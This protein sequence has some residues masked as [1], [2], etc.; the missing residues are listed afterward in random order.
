MTQ[1]GFYRIFWLSGHSRYSWS[2]WLIESFN[3]KEVTYG[4]FLQ[5]FYKGL[6][7]FLFL[8]DHECWQLWPIVG[9][10]AVD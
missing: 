1:R 10:P 8:I 9:A 6:Y 4:L 7:E 5:G 2:G 3:P